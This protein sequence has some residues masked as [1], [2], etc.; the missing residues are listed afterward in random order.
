MTRDDAE[1]I[2]CE[3]VRRNIQG[4]TGEEINLPFE[5]LKKKTISVMGKDSFERSVKREMEGRNSLMDYVLEFID[6]SKERKNKAHE[7]ENAMDR[8]F[9]V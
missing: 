4:F 1:K 9:E 3:N 5:E 8:E 2:V 6:R 7:Q